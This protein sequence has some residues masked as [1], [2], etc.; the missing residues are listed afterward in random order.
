MA[1]V[2]LPPS[3]PVWWEAFK[4]GSERIRLGTVHAKSWFEARALAE[5]HFGLERGQVDLVPM[6]E[7]A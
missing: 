1:E 5:Q 7:G 2:S 6:K 3:G 4:A